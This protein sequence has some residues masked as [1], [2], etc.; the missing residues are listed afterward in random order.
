M[1]PEQICKIREAMRQI[2]AHAQRID[3]L[4]NFTTNLEAASERIAQICYVGWSSAH[5][6]PAELQKKLRA[7]LTIECANEIAKLELAIMAIP[8][9]VPAESVK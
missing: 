9:P 6:V 8:V 3:Y 2:D 5:E 7:F 4:R 1:T